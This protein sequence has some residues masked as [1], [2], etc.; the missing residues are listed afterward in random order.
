MKNLRKIKKQWI[1]TKKL[2]PNL[3]TKNDNM[4]K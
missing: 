2:Q 1:E 4:I 3:C